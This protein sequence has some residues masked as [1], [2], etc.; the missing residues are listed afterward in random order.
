MYGRSEYSTL[1]T[2]SCCMCHWVNACTRQ[3][4]N[5]NERPGG[6]VDSRSY[7]WKF[8]WVETRVTKL[9]L[10]IMMCERNERVVRSV[11]ACEWCQYMAY[12]DSWCFSLEFNSLGPNASKGELNVLPIQTPKSEVSSLLAIICGPGKVDTRA[13]LFHY[14][15]CCWSQQ[16]WI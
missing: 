7:H 11:A 3:S 14:C 6:S 8:I 16:G 9:V 5:G 12:N 15:C 13:K 10:P 1:C 2:G 4:V